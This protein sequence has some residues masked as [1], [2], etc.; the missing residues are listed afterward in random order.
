M[1]KRIIITAVVLAAIHFVLAIGS[2]MISFGSG[3]EAFDNPDYQPSLV[4]RVAGALAGILMQPGMSLWT[5]WMSKNMPNVVEWGLCLLNS[6]LWGIVLA[7]ILNAPTLLKRKRPGNN[8][9]D[10]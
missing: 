1:K 4:E 6:L 8:A 7:V 9:L 2:V 3:M 5:P 10:L